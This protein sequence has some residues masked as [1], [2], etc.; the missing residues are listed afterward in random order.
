MKKS[1]RYNL[2]FCLDENYIPSLYYVFE[3][4]IKFNNPKKFIINFV[5]T[6]TEMSFKNFSKC[7]NDILNDISVEFNINIKEF[8]PSDEF[9]SLLK[10]YCLILN[11]YI[12]SRPQEKY[13]K[14]KL[15]KMH[16]FYNIGNWSRFYISEL[17]PL[18]KKGLYLDL[19][20]LFTGNI[21][22]LFNIKLK[23]KVLAAHNVKNNMQ[24]GLD[25]SNSDNTA[26]GNYNCGVM[27][28]N[29]VQYRK[30]NI[31]NQV[32]ELLK[33]SIESKKKLF[34]GTQG[35]QN[36]IIDDYIL[37]PKKYNFIFN[38]K[39]HTDREYYK[40]KLQSNIDEGIIIHFKGKY[41][42]WEYNNYIHYFY[43]IMN[44]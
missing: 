27:L 2:F 21:E 24:S 7:I 8:I 9:V 25:I 14:A 30:K 1:D 6:R 4:F 34:R 19:D 35:I 38:H 18:I 32:L 40:F 26:L 36:L 33:T 41:H 23:T 37:L 3:T 20:I 17:F 29:F 28:F 10:D 11:E 16:I 42:H 12:E 22:K 15:D 13:G 31:L 5:I 44:M 43:H 39:I